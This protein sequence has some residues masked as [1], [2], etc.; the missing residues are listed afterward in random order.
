MSSILGNLASQVL[1]GLGSASDAPSGNPLLGVI[2]Q[3]LSAPGGL[4][5]LVD[6]FQKAGLGET[7]SSWIST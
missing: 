1:G 7:M 3:L 4:S 6:Q 2:A 5:G